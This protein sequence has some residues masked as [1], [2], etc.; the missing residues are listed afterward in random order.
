MGKN[1]TQPPS[2]FQTTINKPR[3]KTSRHVCKHPQREAR[4]Q[5]AEERLG[6]KK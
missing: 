2:Y 3:V 5:G 4:R 1:D 6:G